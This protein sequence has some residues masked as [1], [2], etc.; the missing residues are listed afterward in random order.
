MSNKLDVRPGQDS[1]LEVI[2]TAITQW[3]NSV[4]DS[5]TD[6]RMDLIRDKSNAVLDFFDFTEKPI[7]QIS[8]KDVLEW[9]AE[10]EKQ[11]LAH[12]TVYARLCHI[13]SF[14]AHYNLDNPVTLAR[15]KAPK[16]YQN[17]KA[18]SLSNDEAKALIQVIRQLAESDDITAKRDYAVTLFLFFSG[19]RRN[20]I[21]KLRRKDIKIN[22][23]V[24][25]KAKVKGGDYVEFEVNHPLAKN[26]LL[27]YLKATGR[28][29]ETMLLD[30]AL[31]IAHRGLKTG[32]AVTSHTIARRLKRYAEMAGLEHFHM[33]QTRHTFARLVSE[34]TGS[35]QDTQDALGH[36]NAATTKVYVQRIAIKKDKHS[37][38]I[39]DELGI[40]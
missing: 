1:S 22:G 11:N 10:L 33:H 23:T 8:S 19:K 29:F 21:I 16:A 35:I 28:D 4:T 12:S 30:D 31:W 14:Y 17:E 39:A 37:Q 3:I 18:Q 24:T 7:T 32:Q 2:S 27:D 34:K 40:G 25:I 36:K 20:E 9:Q 15:P 13:S 6:R 26:A 38:H 5:E